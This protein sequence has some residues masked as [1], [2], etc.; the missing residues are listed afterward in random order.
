MIALS[1]VAAVAAVGAPEPARPALGDRGV[2][3]VGA[4]I[5]NRDF[6]SQLSSGSI[7]GES[8]DEWYRLRR[9]VLD[10]IGVELN[11][12]YDA[13]AQAYVGG[14]SVSGFAGQLALNGRWFLFGEKINAPTYL[15]FRFRERHRL[16]GRAPSEIGNVVGAYWETVQGFNAAGFEIP[17]FFIEQTYF[18]EKL[19]LRF[20]Q[21]DIKNLFDNHRLG[22]SRQT[23]GN[24]A[25]S[26]SPAVGFP[27]FGAGLYARWD[28]ED[29]WDL[30]AAIAN[31]QRT[32][33]YG[34]RD[35][36]VGRNSFFSGIQ[37][38]VNFEG[39][40][41]A[42]S[43]VQILGWHSDSIDFFAQPEGWGL[44]LTYEQELCDGR[45]RFFARYAY[46]SG[47]STPIDN[48][49]AVGYGTQV[50]NLDEAGFAIGVGRKNN[51]SEWQWVS[52]VFY[53]WQVTS[54]LTVHPTLQLLYGDGF[55][56]GNGPHLVAG[57]HAGLSF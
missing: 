42:P 32:T 16:G 50:R 30:S 2:D 34:G 54:E 13:Y 18:D 17:D 27:G 36:D 20:G 33:N 10:E 5:E 7:F 9:E 40:N 38:G 51:E 6:L 48:L 35:I 19:D 12:T 56:D 29:G 45:D 1:V 47:G 11:I 55:T 57:L 25:F 15:G 23:F 49:F 3:D 28:N 43:R 31:I 37:F 52:E 24:R 39:F 46:E 26:G 4:T 8:L 22:S 21:M 44:S 41:R 14:Q 53:R